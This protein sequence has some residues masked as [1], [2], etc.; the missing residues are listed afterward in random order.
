MSDLL[1]ADHL[2]GVERL[3]TAA[4][5][6]AMDRSAIEAGLA[7]IVLMRRAGAAAF[8]E[9]RARWPDAGALT[10]YCGRG[11]NAGDGYVV[12]GLAVS[13]GFEVELLQL[14]D[15]ADLSGDAA[16]ARDWAV[17]EGVRIERFAPGRGPRGELLV[18]ALLGTGLRGAVRPA[19]A[20]AVDTINGAGCPVFAVD[21][22]TG[23]D[24]DTGAELGTAVRA[25]LTMTF[26]AA[27]RGLLT[28]R[29]PA[30]TGALRF[31]DLGVPAA[32]RTGTVAED[33]GVALLRLGEDDLVLAPRAPD[34]HKGAFGHVL[35]VGGDE[36]LGGAVLLATE[37][38]LR[39]GA[40]LV[41]CATR[42][43]HVPALLARTPEVMVRAVEHRDALAP[44]LARATAVVVGP[45][46]GTGPWGEQLLDAVLEAGRP[47]VLDADALNLLAER[48][49]PPAGPPRI[50]TPHPGEAAR[51]LA[52][53][54]ATVQ[55]DRFAAA[56]ALARRLG[57]TTV[58]KGAGTLVATD[59]AVALCPLGN[60]GLAGGGTG[61][62]LAGILGAL[63]AQGLDADRA[64]RLGVCLHGAAADRAMA[65]R[66]VPGLVASDLSGPLAPLVD[67][68]SR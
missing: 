53:D 33:P 9:L 35:V 32:L 1:A 26:I 40:G 45:G 68:V 46:L 38:A 20:E 44:L 17:G 57:A 55:G 54:P 12:A 6:G 56:T 21:V 42:A 13:R 31:D 60:P 59:D 52:T 24:A 18:D 3:Y 67:A 8:A 4:A 48:G 16:R 41:S 28:G 34:A 43:A 49:P 51:L 19:F 22:P 62:V 58:L 50:V 14:G 30:L 7:G 23:L 11:N 47:A 65:A 2:P 15:P 37:A 64:A 39:T 36:G 25:D 61:D 63:L 27:K 66:G 10:V 29:G 5:T